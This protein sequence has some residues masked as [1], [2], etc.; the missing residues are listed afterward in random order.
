MIAKKISDSI[1]E[2]EIAENENEVTIYARYENSNKWIMTRENKAFLT[3]INTNPNNK[4]W[5]IPFDNVCRK[6]ISSYYNENGLSDK[7]KIPDNLLQVRG[8]L[9]QKIK[10]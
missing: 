8:L 4:I 5:D 7:N 3:P 10:K 9:I 6:L 2:V 1:K